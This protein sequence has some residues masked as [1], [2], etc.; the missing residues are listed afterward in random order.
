MDSREHIFADMPAGLPGRKICATFGLGTLTSADR[1]DGTRNLSFVCHTSTGQWFVRRRHEGYCDEKRIKFD[2]EAMFYLM[3]AGLPVKPPLPCSGENAWW[4][5]GKNVWEAFEFVEGRP[6]RDGNK[7]DAAFLGTALGDFHRAGA[8]FK[9][10]YEKLGARGETDPEQLMS[11]AEKLKVSLRSEGGGPAAP[12]AGSLSGES[13]A[14]ER[15][16]HLMI[17][18]E[19]DT[20]DLD[21]VLAPYERLIA[22]AARDFT[23]A[24]C[25]ALPQTL[26]HGDIQPANII[27]GD[28]G[29]NAFVDF[30]WC[31]W[32]PR[33]YD[34]AF[35]VLFCCSFHEHPL[36]NGDIW[37][38]TQTPEFNA[39]AM[40]SFM[41]VYGKNAG[42]L[43][44]EERKYF[45]A[46]MVL[47][48][49]HARIDGAFKVPRQERKNFL[50]RSLPKDIFFTLSTYSTLNC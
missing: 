35:A 39:E 45:G 36:G 1:M 7:Q 4:H 43:S 29:V 17:G 40:E 28:D 37:A 6:L 19:N 25:S 20:S 13:A 12:R 44:D 22:Q 46:Q 42:V 5:D 31:A 3:N 32:R 41:N 16:G 8:G 2:H 49:C 14:T 27:M 21:H 38:L 15:D 33:I 10:R 34:L 48:W 23:G 30:D 47:A 11:N 50:A 18:L 26:V 24:A 9:L